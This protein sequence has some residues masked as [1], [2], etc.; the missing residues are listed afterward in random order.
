METKKKLQN[1]THKINLEGEL[2]ILVEETEDDDIS[3]CVEVAGINVWNW[4]K[5]NEG[6]KV[7]LSFERVEEEKNVM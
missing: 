6:Q 1:M 2:F 7:R 3:I 5:N 4:L